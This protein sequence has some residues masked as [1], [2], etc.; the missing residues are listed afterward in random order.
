MESASDQAT[1]QRTAERLQLWI[2]PCSP[3]RVRS[4]G[5]REVVVL[6]FGQHAHR[7]NPG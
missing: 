3:I 4:V 2:A 7:D 6:W 1:V 5:G